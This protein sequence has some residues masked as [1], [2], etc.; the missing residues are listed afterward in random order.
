ML[1]SHAM[2]LGP[3]VLADS[4]AR[5]AAARMA[6]SLA[7]GSQASEIRAWMKLIEE[8]CATQRE[9][10]RT[11]LSGETLQASLA[12]LDAGCQA[13]LASLEAQART[14]DR[15]RRRGK[16]FQIFVRRIARGLGKVA[17]AAVVETPRFIFK[18]IIRPAAII[19]VEEV[20]PGTINEFL[21]TALTGGVPLRGK[22]FSRLLRQIF[23][24]RLKDAGENLASERVARLFAG[25][26]RRAD[27]RQ[28]AAQDGQSAPATIPAEELEE[29]FSTGEQV[30]EVK[31]TESDLRSP[32][33]SALSSHRIPG[34]SDRA[35]WCESM[36]VGGIATDLDMWIRF[37]LDTGKVEGEFGGSYACQSGNSECDEPGE[38]VKGRLDGVI[39][40]GWVRPDG[41]GGWEWGGDV[42][43]EASL[44]AETSCGKII[45]EDTG[46][47]QDFRIR[48]S[49]AM[50]VAG[51]LEGNTWGAPGAA[52]PWFALRGPAVD[53]PE[54]T[55]HLRFSISCYSPGC[56]FK[57]QFP[58]PPG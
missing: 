13:D 53:M 9:T 41:K 36:N 1:A 57:D 16:G 31:I 30:I 6:P 49:T 45:H 20:A 11:T 10:L 22:A 38:F 56:P 47:V 14:L 52:G 29:L 58:P 2:V 54:D 46:E 5:A 35:S 23:Q 19:L 25:R 44:S 8:A 3:E 12:E 33:G 48:G 26:R 32:S 51:F 4:G 43:G 21:Q 7:D 28:L 17:K 15:A 34:Q 50:K 42:E 40:N 18:E 24:R 55:P 39:T 27:A 37:N